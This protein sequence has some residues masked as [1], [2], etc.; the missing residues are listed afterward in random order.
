MDFYA[1]V[2]ACIET[3]AAPPVNAEGG[4]DVIRVIEA[5]M[6]S[7][8]LGQALRCHGEQLAANSK[9]RIQS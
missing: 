1:Q 4:R 8:E 6:Q 5:A 9:N 2:R 7:S 3:G